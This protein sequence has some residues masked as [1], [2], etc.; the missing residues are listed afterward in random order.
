VLR[1][2]VQWKGSNGGLDE[3][4]VG[5]LVR[6]A[7]DHLLRSVPG[8]N[9]QWE[10]P[11]LL[12]DKQCV[13]ALV[14]E[15]LDH[16]LGRLPR[17]TVQREPAIYLFDEQSVGALVREALDHLQRRVLASS[18]MQRKISILILLSKQLRIGLNDVSHDAE[19]L[20]AQ[21]GLNQGVG[22]EAFCRTIAVAL[23]LVSFIV[24][25]V[26]RS[27][28]CSLFSAGQAEEGVGRTTRVER[29]GSKHPEGGSVWAFGRSCPP[30]PFNDEI[31]SLGWWWCCCG[32][33]PFL[34]RL[35]GGG[36]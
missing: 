2:K 13:G 17:C 36:S 28:N 31:C 5:A 29:Q 7:L 16:L 35:G 22:H 26:V 33:A 4:C 32:A 14:G 6:E 18:N 3:Q 10:P 20:V 34:L 15:V 12:L 11:I 1:C 30:S 23:L 19:R 24:R 27:L 8:S 9:V 25:S 21:E